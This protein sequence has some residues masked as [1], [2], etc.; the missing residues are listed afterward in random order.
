MNDIL[1][2]VVTILGRLVIG[3]AS[4]VVSYH[5]AIYTWVTV[6]TLFSPGGL[7]AGD[8]FGFLIELVIGTPVCV[9]VAIYSPMVAQLIF[10]DPFGWL[11]RV[12]FSFLVPVIT[13][14]IIAGGITAIL[15]II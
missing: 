13:A 7:E 9:L 11:K 4:L 1:K 3:A 2:Q 14:V 15:E 6:S 10:K 8:S 5:A 12:A